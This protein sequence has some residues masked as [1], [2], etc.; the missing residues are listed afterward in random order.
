ME[1]HLKVSLHIQDVTQR[2]FSEKK[3]YGLV[4]S[5]KSKL[6]TSNSVFSEEKLKVYKMLNVEYVLL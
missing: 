5:T 4:V 3:D 1:K 2:K 6:E